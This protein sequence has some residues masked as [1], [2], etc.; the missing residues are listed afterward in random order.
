M[1]LRGVEVRTAEMVRPDKVEEVELLTEKLSQANAVVLVDFRGLHVQMAE[2]LRNRCRDAEV[3]Y[4][5]VKNTLLQLAAE[6]AGIEGLDDLLTGPTALAISYEDPV[7]P[8]HEIKEFSD[9]FGVLEIKGGVL[10]G[11][12]VETEEVM[13]LADLPSREV[14]L[15]QVAS[16]FAAP[17]RRTA[18]VMQAPMRDLTYA[19]SEVQKKSA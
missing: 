18:T 19:V 15:A 10:E 6:E 2:E 12:R 4:R 1:V 13:R 7:A 16:C 17:M 8:A 9:E 3:E 11:V 5:V 14:L